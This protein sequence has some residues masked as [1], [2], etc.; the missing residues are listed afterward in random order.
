MPDN[1][2][3]H[4]AML[5]SI[6]HAAVHR[7]LGLIGMAWQRDAECRS[8]PA[9]VYPAPEGAE[10]W[11]VEPP[12]DDVLDVVEPKT[13]TGRGALLDALKYAHATYSSVLYLSR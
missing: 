13:F 1:P 4:L 6:R 3:K 2:V 8:R 9:R 10:G 12:S 5:Q 7:M 11:V